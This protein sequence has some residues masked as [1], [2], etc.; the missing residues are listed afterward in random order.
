MAASGPRTTAN[1]QHGGY[2]WR[3]FPAV[4]RRPGRLAHCAGTQSRPRA[5][6][7]SA[8][9]CSV[10]MAAHDRRRDLRLPLGLDERC[11][12]GASLYSPRSGRP[13]WCG[14]AVCTHRRSVDA[15]RCSLW[16]SARC[17]TSPQRAARS[18][19]AGDAG[20]RTGAS[21]RLALARCR[22]GRA[23]V[24]PARYLPLVPGLVGH[25]YT[26]AAVGW[27]CSHSGWC[28]ASRS[29]CF[30]RRSTVRSCVGSCR[31]R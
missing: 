6:S 13:R 21:V 25:L 7:R 20:S 23:A 22:A 3:F 16:R 24:A 5:G 29:K 27:S 30:G 4:R 14:R 2:R 19:V 15:R 8:G 1:R 18:L 9:C 31:Y 26:A 28:R 17:I 12:L 11:S 10:A